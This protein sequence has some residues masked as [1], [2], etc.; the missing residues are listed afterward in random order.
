MIHRLY[1]FNLLIILDY[2]WGY[3]HEVESLFEP[4]VMAIIEAVRGQWDASQGVAPVSISQLLFFHTRIQRTLSQTGFLVG[5]F[6]A[7]PWLFA[8]L[9]TALGPLGIQVCRPDHHAY[10]TRIS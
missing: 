6:A 9:K 5:G 10:D 3:R 7:S 2:V 4:S 8:R 1:P